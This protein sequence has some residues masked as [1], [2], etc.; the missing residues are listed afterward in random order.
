MHALTSK[1]RRA[2]TRKVWALCILRQTALPVLVVALV[3][4][5]AMFV[6]LGAVV[7]GAIR[8]VE[9]PAGFWNFWASAVTNAE[10]HVLAIT[11]VLLVA[12][13]ILIKRVCARG[14]IG[15][16]AIPRRNPI[17]FR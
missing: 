17:G 7:S 8:S 14:L 10:L 12:G 16:A 6:S 4:L 3:A 2:I 15:L 11:A 5:E 13:A 1:T 9:S